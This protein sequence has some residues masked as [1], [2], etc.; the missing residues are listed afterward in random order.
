MNYRN[1]ITNILVA[2]VF[3]GAIAVILGWIFNVS[4]LKSILPIW[5]S[6]KF[7]TAVCFLISSVIVFILCKKEKGQFAELVLMVLS[8]TLLLIMVAFFFSLFTGISTGI[9]SLF[10]KEAPGSVGTSAPGVPAVPTILCFII[11]GF[12]GGVYLFNPEGSLKINISGWVITVIGLVAVMGYL[13]GIPVLYYSF[14]GH[15]SMAFHTAL[16]FTFLG[17]NLSLISDKGGLK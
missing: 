12:A 17:I 8:F 16:F 10:V 1:I 7:I 9:E 13:A 14:P 5:V 3:F 4:A 6:M 2:I 15:T 11:I